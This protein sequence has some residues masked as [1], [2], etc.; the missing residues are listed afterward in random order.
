MNKELEK[1][2]EEV[3]LLIKDNSIYFAHPVNFYNTHLEK[4]LIERI[5]LCFPQYNLENPNQKHHQENYKFWKEKTESGMKYYLDIVLPKMKAG[6]G[7]PFEDNM[8]GAGV[9]GEL[10]FISNRGNPILEINHEGLIKRIKRLDPT[11]KLSVEETRKRV[12]G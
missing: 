11:R 8:Y 1:R 10:E 6:I 2:I 9:F 3:N 12:Y 4:C 5:N 7:L